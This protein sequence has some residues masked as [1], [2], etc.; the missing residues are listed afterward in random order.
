MDQTDIPK[1]REIIDNEE[2]RLVG[3][4]PP[5]DQNLEEIYAT[6]PASDDKTDL[7]L[8]IIRTRTSTSDNNKPLILLFHGGGF[9]CGSPEMLTRPGREFALEFNALVVLATHRKAPEHRFPTP[10]LD[11]W[12]VADW[13]SRN[14]GTFGADPSRGFIV[15]GYSAGGQLATVVIRQSRDKPL[16][17]PVTGCF[18][19]I[20]STLC[21]EIVPDAY[22][23]LWTSMVEN[24]SPGQG[25]ESARAMI[26]QLGADI[27]S[28]WFS[29]FNSAHGLAEMPPTYIQVG[30]KDIYRDDGVVLQK[31][32]Q[33]AG[34]PVELDV[35]GDMGHGSFTVWA[36]G[37]GAH[38]PPDLK[39]KTLRA[40]GRLLGKSA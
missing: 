32:L 24:A 2:T 5:I 38:N 23:P 34:V 18:L 25:P 19:G 29:A 6:A 3:T 14:A 8:K 40:M 39:P 1:L 35:Y 9:F 26:E 33:D 13:V 28:P 30:G 31:A 17:H 16:A 7:P 36:Q 12:H 15:G 11:G 22:R 4:L 21:E 10:M 20:P 37:E 27:R